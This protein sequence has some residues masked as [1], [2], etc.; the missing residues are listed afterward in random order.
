MSSIMTGVLTLSSVAP[1][2]S[3][4][5][6]RRTINEREIQRPG[7]RDGCTMKEIRH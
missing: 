2:K 3:C 4:Q 1:R 6:Y 5:T 7:T